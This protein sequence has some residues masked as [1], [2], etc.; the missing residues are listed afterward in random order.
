MLLY[1]YLLVSC[2]AAGLAFGAGAA[3]YLVIAAFAG[4]FLGMLLVHLLFLV[5]ASLFV[6]KEKPGEGAIG[7]YRKLI[8][9]TADL[10]LKLG[11]VKVRVE[12]AEKLP[13]G[14]CLIVQNHVS[15]FD[16]L[17][18]YPAFSGRRLFFV[19]KKENLAI[20]VGGRL[21]AGFSFLETTVRAC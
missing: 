21:M 14:R 7:F 16:P 1:L 9:V 15:G 8:T 10:L 18:L 11:G 13:E 5:L 20:P 17:A 6:D 12:G 2:A 19:S 3:W 4:A